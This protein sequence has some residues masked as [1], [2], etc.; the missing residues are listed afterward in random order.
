MFMCSFYAEF[1]DSLSEFPN[2][3]HW[4]FDFGVFISQESKNSRVLGILETNLEKSLWSSTVSMLELE[5]KAKNITSSILFIA[6]ITVATLSV[7][8]Q[9]DRV[10][11]IRGIYIKNKLYYKS[12]RLVAH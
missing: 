1:K 5:E 7:L 2:L 10:A 3:G 6:A 12:I 11:E 9:T 8:W 4:V